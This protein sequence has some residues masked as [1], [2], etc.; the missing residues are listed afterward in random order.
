MLLAVLTAALF[1][2]TPA[3]IPDPAGLDTVPFDTRATGLLVE[4]VIRAG[5]TVPPELRDYRAD[6]RSAVYLSVSTDSAQGGETPVTVDEFAG[7]LRWDRGG[8]LRQRVRAHRVRMLTPTPY[9]VGT[10]L[11]SPWIVPHLYGHTID[12]FQL[13]PARPTSGRRVSRAIH[14]FSPRGPDLYRYEAGDTLRVGTQEGVVTLVEVRVRPRA[15]PERGRQVVAGSFYVDVDRA[16]V[17]RARFGFTDPGGGG[18]LRLSRAGIFFEMENGL[19]QGR[20][21]LPYRQRQEVQISSPLFGGAAA[22]RVVSL[23][24]GYDLNTG[25]TPPPGERLALVREPAADSAFRGWRAPIGEGF[26]EVDIQDFEDLRRATAG[27]A[28]DEE[29]VRVSLVPER[30]SDVFR[31]N[32]VE[33]AF[34]GAAG[35]VEIP[36]GSD[37]RW[38][39]YGTAGW[40]FAESTA[41][42]ELLARRV[43]DLPAAPGQARRW[44]V[45]GGAYRRLRDAQAFRPT[46]R[47]ELGYTLAAAL[48]GYD[49]LDYYDAAGV[50]ASTAYRSG[51]WTT[52]LGG[53]WEEHDSVTLNTESFLFGEAERFPPVS[54]ADP[55]THAA[56]EGEVRFGRGAGAFNLGN[57]LIASLRAEGGFG[58]WSFGRLTGLLAARRDVG[59]FTLATRLD[60]GTLAGEAPTQFLF[61]VGE[62]EGFKGYGPNEFGGTTAALGRA[63]LLLHLPPYGQG[64]L[65]RF[66]FFIIPPL[67]P[68]L[69][70]SGSAAWTG[71]A[72][73]SRDELL[74]IRARETDGLLGTT[75]VG[76]SFFEDTFVVEWTRP[77]EGGEGRWYVGLVEW[78]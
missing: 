77:L 58:D 64:P 17:A 63:R 55:G 21:W 19:V 5:S 7:E 52:R 40:A 28:E 44:T 26:G 71:V 36:A 67:R 76:V 65:A 41:R 60:A 2:G 47:W 10:F 54:P 3:P 61:R 59:P 74:R 15:L 45:E 11:E 46:S 39:V 33:G 75:G 8:A 62:A 14:P 24:S 35:E 51:P 48:G 12:V 20:Y 42:G 30:S 4:R 53:R 1:Q 6:F 29:R 50:E 69:V 70:L 68:A 37:A 38:E 32:R 73:D 49:I 16:S 78:F 34:L 31:Y 25:W 66:G 18:L 43:Q 22:L 27:V 13:S 72:E 9:T 23:L 56:L 57:S